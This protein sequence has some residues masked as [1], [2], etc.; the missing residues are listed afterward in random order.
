VIPFYGAERPDLFAVER[1]AVERLRRRIAALDGRLPDR[2]VIADDL[3][4]DRL[5]ARRSATSP[6]THRSGNRPASAA[7]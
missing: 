1:R 7:R 4:H 5:C 2:G 3:G 6:P